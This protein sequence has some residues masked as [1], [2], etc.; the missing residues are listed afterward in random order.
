MKKYKFS[1][2][3]DYLPKSKI[4]AGEG[5]KKGLY[6]LFTSSPRLTKY[7]DKYIYE[8]ES[9]I[10][11][12]GGLPSIHYIDDKFSTST[13][14]IIVQKKKE[15]QN[16]VD[17]GYVY[18]FFKGSPWIL[19]DGF[20]GAGLKHISKKYI[21]NIKIPLPEDIT[22]QIKI[23]NLL[24]QV[25]ALIIKREE[26]IE[27]LDELLKSTF[28][29]MF[30]DP[31][32]NP[33]GWKVKP[34]KKFG[35][36]STGN[37]PSRRED[38]Y[39][40]DNYIE[41]I[42]TDNIKVD[43]M[44]L[45]SAKEYLSKKGLEKGRSVNAG[46]LLVTCI[47]GSLKSIGNA[48][49]TDRKV[50]FNQQINAI[51]PF[52]DVNSL[53]LYWLVKISKEYIQD[54]AGKGMKKMITKSSFEKITFPKPDKLIQDK[55][56]IIVQQVEATKDHYKDSLDELNEL[57]GSLSQRAFR[58]ELDLSGME[59]ESFAGREEET[60]DMPT[61]MRKQMDDIRENATRIQDSIHSENFKSLTKQA[62]SLQKLFN[63]SEIMKEISSSAELFKSL[64]I[65]SFKIDIPPLYTNIPS[66]NFDSMSIFKTSKQITEALQKKKEHIYQMLENIPQI[67]DA[68]ENDVLCKDDFLEVTLRYDYEYSQ[69]KRIIMDKLSSGALTQHFDEESKS[70][71]LAKAI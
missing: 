50:A 36:I 35:N 63:L 29:D 14:C 43:K 59:V 11:G 44:Y 61:F 24:T 1:E 65:P 58:G 26:S 45:T 71:K 67:K 8:G 31:V 20:H 42:K 12:T 19:E 69:I 41:W 52:E 23:A 51:D 64:N 16:K 40:D 37:T 18:Y 6:P 54:Q 21:S 46:S 17:T 30:G 13:D 49:L 2:L 32:L 53:F 66:F 27:L 62:E 47:A 33:K 38:K 5:N 9:L 34:L 60:L 70:I 39:Y 7:F 22:E 57:F 25:E 56:A 28:L 3:F 55:F 68:I 10:F 15:Y 48:S 4:K